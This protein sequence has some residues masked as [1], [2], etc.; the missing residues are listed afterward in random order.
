MRVVCRR[1]GLKPDV[2]RAWERRYGAVVPERTATNRR[3][4]SDADI[5]RLALLH[6]ATLEGWSIGQV[7]GL[8]DRSLAEL[9]RAEGS[10]AKRAEEA[11]EVQPRA[12]FLERCF[13]AVIRLDGEVL[14]EE[15]DRAVVELGQ[16]RFLSGLVVPLMEGVGEGWEQ[17]RLSP[18]HEHVATQ[19]VR[20]LLER[21]LAS[22]HPP[23]GAATV[24][25]AT[26]SGQLHDV[27]ALLVAVAAAGD[28][29]RVAYL[30]PDL[31]ASDIA[32][33]A[34]TLEARAVALS[35]T[36]HEVEPDVGAELRELRRLAPDVALLVGGRAARFYVPAL[37]RLGARHCSDLATLRRQLAA[38]G[39]QAALR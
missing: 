8:D 29:W 14:A 31:P 9:L 4:Y 11:E 17:G 35:V 2:L 5:A 24:V 26:P 12:A 3:L 25:V 37:E 1:T 38:L 34:R 18:A 20:A 16:R 13:D 21:V 33:A 30:G 22:L 32:L 10:A 15:L 28:R 7:A 36:Y 6:R 39:G 27:G 23:S 19:V